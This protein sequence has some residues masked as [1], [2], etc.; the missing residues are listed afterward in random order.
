MLSLV[1]STLKVLVPEWDPGSD[2]AWGSF[3]YREERGGRSLEKR[4]PTHGDLIPSVTTD[5]T[6]RS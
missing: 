2:Q 6:C 3:L 4:T 1:F 5:S